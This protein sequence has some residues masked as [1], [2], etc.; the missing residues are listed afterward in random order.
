VLRELFP[1]APAFSPEHPRRVTTSVTSRSTKGALPPW[2]LLIP[3]L[4]PYRHDCLALPTTKKADVVESREGFDHVG[5]LVNG[6]RKSEVPF[7]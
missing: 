3:D 4:V 2:A 1:V 7:K 6:P 5:L